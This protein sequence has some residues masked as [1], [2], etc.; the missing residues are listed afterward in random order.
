MSDSSSSRMPGASCWLPGDVILLAS[1]RL[2]DFDGEAGDEPR[3]PDFEGD[4]CWPAGD[5]PLTELDSPAASDLVWMPGE[6]LRLPDF[7]GDLVCPAWPMPAEFSS[8]S[9]RGM[10]LPGDFEGDA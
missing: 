9:C 7:E 6:E 4:A 1:F 5:S 8:P 2:P 10:D 3:L